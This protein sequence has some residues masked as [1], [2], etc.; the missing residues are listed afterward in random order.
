M[1]TT[2]SGAPLTSIIVPTYDEEL[3]LPLLLPRLKAAMEEAGYPLEVI[4]ADDSRSDAT[5]EAAATA[6][7]E[8][9][10]NGTVLRRTENRGLSPAVIDGFRAAKGELIGVIDADLSHPPEL[11]PKMIA[12]CLDRGAEL[13]IGSR[14]VKGGGVRDWPFK[15]RLASKVACWMAFPISRVKDATAGFFL[16]KKSVIDGVPLNAAGFKIGLEI[17]VKGNYRTRAEVPFVFADREHGES[18][19]GGKVMI[20]YAFHLMRLFF[21]RLSRFAWRPAKT[22]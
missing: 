3:N 19:L 14:Y 7:A 20:Q 6:F 10:I 9:G 2:N 17:F 4:V 16:F 11:V 13:A 15:R 22:V 1:A 5:E 21:W 12:A 8:H 18:K